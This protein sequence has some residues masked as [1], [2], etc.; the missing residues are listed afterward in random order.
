MKYKISQIIAHPFLLII[1]PILF[2]Y[3]NN[4]HLLTFDGVILPMIGSLFVGFVLWII[5]R[6]ILKHSKKSAIL[7]SVYTVLFFSYGHIFNLFSDDPSQLFELKHEYLLIPFFAFFVFSTYFIVKSKKPFNNATTILNTVSIILVVMLM[8]NIVNY[9]F[10]YSFIDD[11]VETINSTEIIIENSP[12][13]YYLIFDAYPNHNT[14]SKFFEYDNGEFISYLN[15]SGFY[16]FDKS[17]SNYVETF[18][19]ISS[20]LNMKHV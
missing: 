3:S 12:D 5:F 1:F 17:H 4:I 6:L 16:V 15:D 11:G 8:V 13:I 18:L 20:S 9:N 7:V 2:L 19:S 14:L 10:S